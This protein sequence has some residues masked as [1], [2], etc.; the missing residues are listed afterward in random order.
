MTALLILSQVSYGTN[1]LYPTSLL[2][3]KYSILIL[4]L[5][6]LSSV[7]LHRLVYGAM[8]LI[9]VL[10]GFTLVTTIAPCV[11]VA[12]YW[13]YYHNLGAW[14]WPYDRILWTNISIHMFT[15]LMIL[16][17][18]MHFLFTLDVP[19]RRKI[20]IVLLFAFGAMFVPL[21][22][23]TWCAHLLIC[24]RSV[25][26]VGVIRIPVIVRVNSSLDSSW[27]SVEVSIWS[28]IELNTAIICACAMT[29]KPLINRV[30]PRLLTDGYNPQG[31]KD[32]V[33]GGDSG[34]P[35]PLTIGT[36]RNRRQP[37]RDDDLAL[38]TLN[39]RPA[40]FT[41][42]SSTS[43]GTTMAASA[44]SPQPSDTPRGDA[45]V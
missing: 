37:P 32:D 17:L 29:L 20:G 27:D 24:L 3:I 5:R 36:R 6:I 34:G 11:P 40:V 38:D 4:Y 19:W 15:E 8:V 33:T 26:I 31:S 45:S 13:D 23:R 14:C 42:A 43:L 1:L 28:A 2:T 21:N 44:P 10:G 12:A 16:V 39:E 41:S 7:F 22:L 35:H 9:A 30:F 25:I 18:P